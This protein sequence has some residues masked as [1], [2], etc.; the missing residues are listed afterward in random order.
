[1]RP[2][3]TGYRP[4]V[5]RTWW[6]RKRSYLI[7]M[8]RDFSPVPITLWLIWLLVELWRLRSGPAGYR[9]HMSAA[10][11]VFSA[12]CLLFALL[13][14]VTF[15]SLSGVVM[16][17]RLGSRSVKPALVTATMFGVWI[18]ASVVVGGL[19]MWLAR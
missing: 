14:S 12:V 19:L 8:L 4:P 2:A 7:Y 17:V 1:M 11:V 5:S 6:L 15:L 9:P 3:T 18:G 16:R 13:H 10:F